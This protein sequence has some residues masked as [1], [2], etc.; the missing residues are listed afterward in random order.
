MSEATAPAEVGQEPGASVGS[1]AAGGEAA[2]DVKALAFARRWLPSVVTGGGLLIAVVSAGIMFSVRL[3]AVEQSV[4]EIKQSG[5]PHVQILQSRLG[6][7]DAAVITD[8]AE[9]MKDHELLLKIDRKLSLLI[10]KGDT[11]KCSE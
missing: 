7:I 4:A 6:T 5:S 8:R 9:R 2:D 10:C 3:G 1:T 11:T